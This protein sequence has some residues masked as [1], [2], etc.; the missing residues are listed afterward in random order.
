MI[1][2]L[3]TSPRVCVQMFSKGGPQ[4]SRNPQDHLR[5]CEIQNSFLGGPVVKNVPANAGDT[6]SISGPGRFHML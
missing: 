4:I 3:G 1:P 5:V 2:L 6:G